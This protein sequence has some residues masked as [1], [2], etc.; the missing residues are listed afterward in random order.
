[1]IGQTSREAGVFWPAPRVGETRKGRITL[2]PLSLAPG[3]YLVAIGACSEDYS[4]CYALTDLSL[5][6]SVRADFPTWGKFL[7]PIRWTPE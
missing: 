5:R 7:H 6:F 4:L 1:V 2:A 3:D